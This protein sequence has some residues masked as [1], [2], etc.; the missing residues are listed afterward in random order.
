MLL[1]K[2]SLPVLAALASRRG[3]RSCAR[4]VP[5]VT[6]RALALALKDLQARRARRAADRGRVSAASALLRRRRRGA[7]CSASSRSYATSESAAATSPGC[8]TGFVHHG[9]V[10]HAVPHRLTAALAGRADPLAAGR[11]AAELGLER[12]RALGAALGPSPLTTL[13]R[14]R[15]RIRRARTSARFLARLDER[16]AARRPANGSRIAATSGAPSRSEAWPHRR[17]AV[18]RRPDDGGRPQRRGRSR[19]RPLPSTRTRASTRGPTC[20]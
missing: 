14:K 10:V 17:W 20:P 11:A 15:D 8:P 9:H 16:V 5:G 4:R 13:S 3:S 7:G 18:A 6:P 2:W 1:R 12:R 19:C